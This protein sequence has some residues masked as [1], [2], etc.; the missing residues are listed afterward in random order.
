MEPKLDAGLSE[1][2]RFLAR[3]APFDALAPEELGEVVSETQIEFYL[4]GAVIL[5]EDGGPV[6]FLRVI[7]SGGVDIVHDGK[8]LDLLSAGDTFG[9]AAM[10]SGLPPGFDARAA[11]DTLCYRIPAAV[12][13]PLLDRAR[14]RELNSG[15][16]EPRNRPVGTLIRSPT[17]SCE[18]MTSVREVA[19]RMT[20]TGAGAAVVDFGGRGFGIVTD[21]DIRTKVVAGG[22]PATTAAAGVMTTPA[23]SVTPDQLG[24]EVLFEMLERGI[25]HA[26]VV[27]D[28]GRL[29]G[30]VGEADL[31]AVQPRS[32]FGA[33][34]RISRA[35]DVGALVE[36][37]RAIPE[38]IIELHASSLRAVEVARVQSALYDALTVRALELASRAFELPPDGLVW[39]AIGSQA[40]RELTPG[41]NPRGALVYTDP[42]PA[43]WADAVSDAFERCGLPAEVPMRSTGGWSDAG[44]EELALAVLVERRALWGTPRDPLPVVDGEQLER[45]IAALARRALSNQPPTGFDADAVI[46][47]DGTRRE[48]LDIRHAAVMPLVELARWAGAAAGR[49]EG[50][51]VDRLRAAGD[52]GVLSQGDARTLIDAFELALELRLAHHVEQLKGGS[53]P[54]D[55]LEPSTMSD[56]TRGHLREVFRAVAAVQRTLQG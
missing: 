7:H 39:V 33:R 22:M 30:V 35:A 15:M 32:W 11:E 25:R 34:R 8:L 31:F 44:E 13:R 5:S 40:R 48:L 21:R 9:H 24:G 55:M 46:E 18:P 51:T 27:S 43:G 28:R 6:T 29:I 17:V 10:L 47:L 53:E 19:R 42:P 37:R 1:V 14:S 26:L 3:R 12:A 41:S 45:V 38:L 20:D 54:D 49:L 2:A 4:A 36:V 56:L 16:N 23:F 50:S 52:A